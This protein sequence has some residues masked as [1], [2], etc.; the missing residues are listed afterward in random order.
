MVITV[1]IFTLFIIIILWLVYIVVPRSIARVT[2]FIM[3]FCIRTFLYIEWEWEG[4]F[5]PSRIIFQFQSQ[6]GIRASCLSLLL[7]SL[8]RR[9]WPMPPWPLKKFFFC[10]QQSCSFSLIVCIDHYCYLSSLFVIAIGRHCC[11]PSQFVQ[12]LVDLD[13]LLERQSTLPVSRARYHPGT[14]T[15][16][17]IDG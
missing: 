12:R 3:Y 1:R 10:N 6:V 17:T 8:C 14:A 5:K 7:L 4:S 11:S 16:S 2:L 9:R 13:C 15:C